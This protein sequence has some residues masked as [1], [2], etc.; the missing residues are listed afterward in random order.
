MSEGEKY[1]VLEKIGEFS[2]CV[3]RQHSLI[4][5]R[6]WFLRSYQKGAQEAGW[7]GPLPQG[8]QLLAHVAKGARTAAC[9][10]CHSL[11]TSASKHLLILPPRALENNTR[12]PPVHGILWEWRLG[13]RHQGS[14]GKETVCGGRLCLEHVLPTGHR[15][16]QVSLW[17]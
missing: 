2:C 13:A 15:S 14:T 3:R 7:P 12:P 16:I 8:D 5:H 1:E 17:R 4:D 11:L 6:T 10:V 9:R